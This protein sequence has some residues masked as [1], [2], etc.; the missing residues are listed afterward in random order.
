MKMKTGSCTG[1]TLLKSGTLLMGCRIVGES[2]A[3]R[4]LYRIAGT[5]APLKTK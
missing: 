4:N 1:C 2:G 5:K 3:Q